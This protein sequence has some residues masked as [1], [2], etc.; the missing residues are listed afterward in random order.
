MDFL[1]L[2]KTK[3]KKISYSKTIIYLKT[4]K[5]SL[6]ID[7]KDYLNAC[8]FLF[9]VIKILLTATEK[10]YTSLNNIKDIY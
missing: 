1:K 10:D 8:N 9:I 2:N 6:E 5:Y 4:P 7:N 3:Y